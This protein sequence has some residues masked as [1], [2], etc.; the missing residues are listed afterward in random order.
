MSLGSENCSLLRQRKIARRRQYLLCCFL[1]WYTLYSKKNLK[2]RIV[3]PIFLIIGSYFIT[4]LPRCRTDSVSSLFKQFLGFYKLSVFHHF[5]FKQCPPIN[6]IS[7]RTNSHLRFKTQEAYYILET[8]H[9][10]PRQAWEYRFD[11]GEEGIMFTPKRAVVSAQPSKCFSSVITSDMLSS[12][13]ISS[14]SQYIVLYF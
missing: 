3:T 1:I 14:H 5:A 11:G 7:R 6:P 4:V 2:R 12:M 8:M 9:S 10:R 13:I